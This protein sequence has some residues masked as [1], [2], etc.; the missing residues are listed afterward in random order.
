MTGTLR[1]A[2]WFVLL[3]L[4]G[5]CTLGAVALVIRAFLN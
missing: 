4:A 2:M 1:K 3:Y 5:I